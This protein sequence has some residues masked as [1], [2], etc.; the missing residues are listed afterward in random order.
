MRKIG[1][2]SKVAAV[3]LGTLFFGAECGGP[4]WNAAVTS[5]ILTGPPGLPVGAPGELYDLDIRFN[6]PDPQSGF[7]RLVSTVVELRSNMSGV[8]GGGI[9]EWQAVDILTSTSQQHVSFTLHCP[10]NSVAGFADV[11]PDGSPNNPDSGLG[12]TDILGNPLAAPVFAVVRFP[13]G[14]AATS[15]VLGV[16]CV[17]N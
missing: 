3:L 12:G 7:P 9:F 11:A 17:K 16:R 2:A 5:I 14:S 10:G 4:P 15:N 8:N 13:D 6:W 1:L